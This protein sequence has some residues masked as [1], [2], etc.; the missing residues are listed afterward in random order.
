M[1]LNRHIAEYIELVRSGTIEICKEQ[2][3]VCDLVEKA[4]EQENIHCDDTQLDRYLALQKYFPYN[5]LSWER[6]L[7]ALHNCVYRAD[8]QLR[9]PVLIAIVGRGT[10]KNGY[11]SFEN[12]SLLTPV[13][14]VKNYH[15]DTYATSEDQAKASWLDIYD[16]LENDKKRFSK[17][18]YWTKE[19]IKNIK[20]G[21]EYRYRTSAPKTKDGGRLGKA[22]FDEYHAYENYDLIDVVITGLGKKKYPRRTIIST[23]GKVRGGPFD[24]LMELC[25]QIL[26]GEVSDNGMLPFICRIESEEEIKD[27]NKWVKANPSLPYFPDLQYEMELEYVSYIQNPIANA[28]FAIKRMNLPPS[29]TEGAVTTWEN[30]LATNRPI[31][32]ENLFGQCCI[33]GIDYAKTTDFVSAGLLFEINGADVWV[34]HTWVCKHSEDL[35]RIKAPLEQWEQM[36]DLTII[37]APEISPELPVFWLA[38]TAAELG[39]TIL[40]VAIDSYR[41]ALMKKAIMDYLYMSD[42]DGYKNVILT[43]PSDQMYNIPIITSGFINQNIIWGDVPLMRWAAWNAKQMTSPAGNVTYGKIEPKSRKTDPFMAYV[44]A[45]CG[46]QKAGVSSGIGMLP[47]SEDIGGCF[48]Y[49]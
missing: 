38:Q 20:T 9:W 10:G 6:F 1:T 42:E 47:M 5:L 26:D 19:V 39:A 21:S 32:R 33:A 34:Q 17:S 4:F 16:I 2:R 3:Q 12:F 18:F 11:L 22:D 48:V 49:D 40:F 15:I 37:D 30:I 31:E 7:F 27:K 45:K 25:E 23:N 44:A 29:R 46:K 41:Y 24:D 35:P 43:R 13:N 14:G 36:G 8:G 28:S